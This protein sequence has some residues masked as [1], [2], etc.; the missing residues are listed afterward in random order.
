MKADIGRRAFLGSAVAV[1]VGSIGALGAGAVTPARSGG[2]ALL[3]E[4]TAQLTGAA[5]R[6]QTRP[7]EAARQMAA[8]MRLLAE[9]GTVNHVDDR[10]KR[11]VEARLRRQGREAILAQPF[12]F[13]AELTLRGWTLPPG[14]KPLATAADHGDSLDDL[15]AHG[16]TQHW[17]DYAAAFER[18]ATS[19][20]RSPRLAPSLTRASFQ[21]EE[22]APPPTNCQ[23]AQF[24]M[25]MLESQL[26]LACTF[27]MLIGPE[28]CVIFGAIALGWK[29]RMWWMGC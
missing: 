8:A 5:A 26:F 10:L 9:W 1:G 29:W 19:L 14:F 28:F 3:D 22:E 20:E 17:R 18:A 11:E 15:R 27:G 2:D 7:G 13:R 24:M 6:M 25:T 23:G 4:I 16:L 12:D 21:D